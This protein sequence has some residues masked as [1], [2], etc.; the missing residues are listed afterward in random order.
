MS[1]SPIDA[2]IHSYSEWEHILFVES[3]VEELSREQKPSDIA[4]TWALEA[5][6][7]LE[8]PGKEIQK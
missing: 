3:K 1:D 4:C 6:R 5:V 7:S 2:P 8:S